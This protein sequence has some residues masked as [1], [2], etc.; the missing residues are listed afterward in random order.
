MTED[1]DTEF[2]WKK[3]FAILLVI[4]GVGGSAFVVFYFWVLNM[5]VQYARHSWWD[6]S[7]V[8]VVFA[9]GLLIS[10]LVAYVGIRMLRQSKA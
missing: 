10:V 6:Y 8:L 5:M 4:V 1:E 7:W 3:L 9:G 2:D